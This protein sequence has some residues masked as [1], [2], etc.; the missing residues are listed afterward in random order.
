MV[1]HSDHALLFL[2]ELRF[3]IVIVLLRR[4]VR[5]GHPIDRI[6]LGFSRRK[7]RIYSRAD[8]QTVE[9]KNTPRWK[10]RGAIFIVAVVL[11]IG[12]ALVSYPYLTQ[13]GPSKSKT[14]S[15]IS[16]CNSSYVSLDSPLGNVTTDFPILSVPSNG[17]G[18]I[19][20]TYYD[21]TNASTIM[22]FETSGVVV[23]NFAN[24]T[25]TLSQTPGIMVTPSQQSVTMGGNGTRQ[26]TIAYAIQTSA[27]SKG[28]YYLNI[29]YLTPVLC[30]A[31]FAFAVGYTFSQ[32]NESGSYFP[33]P[34]GYADHCIQYYSYEQS[35]L[36]AHVTGLE[37]L[38]ETQVGCGFANCDVKS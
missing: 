38:E 36:Y 21:N 7:I 4:C 30:Q 31:E 19:C 5:D 35:M 3:I 23:G 12:L 17:M 22:N 18:E 24:S 28:F 13:S 20:I 16:G 15:T 29:P 6:A 11:V 32:A 37:G 8:Y 27:S 10:K 2:N 14:A 33:L 1:H 25:S 26:V 9:T 34:P